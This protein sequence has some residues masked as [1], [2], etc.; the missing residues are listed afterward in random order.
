MNYREDYP[1]YRLHKK[2]YINQKDSLFQFMSRN[3]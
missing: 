2:E 3:I 1:N